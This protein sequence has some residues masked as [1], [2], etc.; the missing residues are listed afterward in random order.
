MAGAR[1][2]WKI[3]FDPEKP[4][5]DG[6]QE[7]LARVYAQTQDWQAAMTHAGF[8]P[9]R[10]N[11]NRLTCQ[12]H[13]KARI[14]FLSGQ[15]QAQI[16]EETAREAAVTRDEVVKTYR[17][18]IKEARD[19]ERPDYS[20]ICKAAEGLGRSIGM[21]TERRIT[22][23]EHPDWDAMTA[24]ELQAAI[25]QATSLMDP[26]ELRAILGAASR[27]RP[28]QAAEVGEQESD[29]AVPAVSET[30]ALPPTR[31]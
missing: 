16:I 2:A 10:Q 28:D 26:N 13:L 11:F 29:P 9:R 4:I 19:L 27:A 1:S 17:E 5:P 6:K 20:A 14:E 22:E 15:I 8:S 7:T 18:V 30:G 31:H 23:S 12:P 25:Q 3:N 21:F 24:E